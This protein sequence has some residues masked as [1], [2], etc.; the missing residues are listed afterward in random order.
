M[1]I[2]NFNDI[3][4]IKSENMYSLRR[5]KNA[6][7]DLGIGFSNFLF[8]EAFIDNHRYNFSCSLLFLLKMEIAIVNRRKR[9]SVC[10]S[11]RVSLR[12]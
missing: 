11:F 12:A 2:C 6:P 8:C 3:I 5:E 9:N 7:S 4:K 1:I 10:I